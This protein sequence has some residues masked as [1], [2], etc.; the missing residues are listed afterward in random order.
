[1]IQKAKRSAAPKVSPLP[2]ALRG[3]SPDHD[4]VHT[5]PDGFSVSGVSTLYDKEGKVAVQWVKSRQ[6][7]ARREAL[8]MAAQQGFADTIVR[9][10]PVALPKHTN[11]DLCS[12]YV[13]TDYHLGMLSWGEECGADW[14]LKIAED[15]LVRWFAA[16]IAAAPAAEEAVFAQLGDFLHYDSL[17]AVTPTS[18]HLLDADGRFQKLVRSCIRVLRQVISMLLEKH[19]KVR[20]IMAEGNHDLASSVWLREWFAALYE[21]EPR[22]SVDRNPDPYYAHRVGNTS[23]FFHHGHKKK[24]GQVVDVLA[25]KFRKLMGQT[26]YS[27][28]HLGHLHHIEQKEHNLMVVEQHRTLAAPDAYASR[29]GWMSGRDA[30]VITY[31]REF[32][33][34]QRHRISSAM[35]EQSKKKPK[36]SQ[37]KRPVSERHSRPAARRRH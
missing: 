25:G 35:I 15:L 1:M 18:K 29:G 7:A 11:P 6:D 10:K 32:G 12:L 2:D 33:E 31:H 28:A 16:A 13:V 22:V 14:D 19:A 20:I 30:T 4:M 26:K 17:E 3:L 36:K 24:P 5:V 37:P 8:F 34:V 27:Y 23:L 9:A 21:K